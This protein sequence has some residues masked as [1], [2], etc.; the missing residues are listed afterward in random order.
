M[1][2]VLITGARAPIALDFCRSFHQCGMEVYLADSFKYPASRW[3]NQKS[4]YLTLPSARFETTAYI[5]C[6]IDLVK[7]YD[8]TDLIPLCEDV[9]YISKFKEQI[10]CRVWLM[11]F[12]CL[13]ALHNKLTFPS[14]VADYLPAVRSIPL[15]EFKD[16][17][18][19]SAYVF[20]PIYSRFAEKTII[21][22]SVKQNDFTELQHNTWIVQPYIKG[23]EICVFTIWD[24]GELRA[25]RSYHPK[26]RAGQ[27]AGI[28]FQ[29][30]DN[31]AVQ[32]L[33][34]SYG[35]Q[36]SFTGMLSFDVIVDQQGQAHF[37]EC[38]PRAT[39]GAHL[40]NDR[41]ALCFLG[42]QHIAFEATDYALRMPL[43][44]NNPLLIFKREFWSVKEVCFRSDDRKPFN[45]QS[46]ALLELLYLAYHYKTGI[47]SAT[48][49]DMEWNGIL[50]EK[51][52]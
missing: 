5:D 32:S 36:L 29:A 50:E 49:Y 20:K 37:I 35:E 11:D 9:F 44:F 24:E 51:R 19:S 21:A 13:N 34:R 8:I 45:L 31:T 16:W 15:R 26:Y 22:K 39:S 7:E 12:D 2:H 23:H 43:L 30:V 3:T 14:Y 52:N 47:I 25:Y 17:E 4:G 18:H 41:L 33:V 38:N 1:K 40:L 46:L 6:I 28:Y 10:P 48:T 42:E 27:G